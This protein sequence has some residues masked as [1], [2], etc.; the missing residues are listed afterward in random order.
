MENGKD[1]PKSV[2]WGFQIPPGAPRAKWFKL[3]LEPR[4][5]RSL[6][7]MKNL[8][9]TGGSG[10]SESDLREL[11][12]DYLTALRE[13]LENVLCYKVGATAVKSTPITYCITIPV[14]WS[15][16]ALKTTI[17]C[18]NA[19]GMNKYADLVTYTEPE[20]AAT[21]A[22]EETSKTGLEIGSTFVLCDAGGGT[23]DLVSYEVMALKPSLTLREAAVGTNGIFGGTVIN[24]AF[25]DYLLKQLGTD[26]DWDDTTLA[27]AMDAFERNVKPSFNGDLTKEYSIPGTI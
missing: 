23:V 12:T 8:S 6:F 1:T 18:A 24:N 17:D 14:V 13:H 3:A 20:S 27:E 19:A 5:R 7:S 4:R 9:E 22:L 25:Q 15:E 10:H 2:L 26:E 16:T 21:Y 11:I